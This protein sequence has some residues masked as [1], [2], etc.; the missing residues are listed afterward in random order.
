MLLI[1]AIVFPFSR[2]RCPPNIH[3]IPNLNHNQHWLVKM[4]PIRNEYPQTGY[5]LIFLLFT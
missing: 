2:Y 1:K 4:I 5:R 3:E